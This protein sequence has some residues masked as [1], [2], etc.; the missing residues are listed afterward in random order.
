M[1]DGLNGLQDEMRL[2]MSSSE[3]ELVIWMVAAYRPLGKSLVKL[4]KLARIRFAVYV[5]SSSTG[6]GS[7][8]H[9]PRRWLDAEMQR[10]RDAEME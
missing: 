2:S 1:V 8:G 9:I 7:P 5:S 6:S 4:R 10:C 3:I